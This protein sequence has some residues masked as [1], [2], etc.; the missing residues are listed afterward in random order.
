VAKPH[1]R[2]EPKAWADD[3]QAGETEVSTH[4]PEVVQ[5]N[6]QDDMS[7]DGSGVPVHEH[8]QPVDPTPHSPILAILLAFVAIVIVLGLFYLL[9]VANRL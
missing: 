7:T 3:L 2:N 6:E 9:M 1:R 4:H 5:V 8:R